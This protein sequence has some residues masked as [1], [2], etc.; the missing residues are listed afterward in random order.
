[1]QRKR[2]AAGAYEGASGL[3]AGG[4]T[5]YAGAPGRRARGVD[6]DEAWDTRVGNE[7]D[8]YGAP[9]EETELG[10]Q[11][12]GHGG[13][14]GSSM[15]AYGEG[16]DRGRSRSRDAGVDVERRYHEET[17]AGGQTH[18]GDNPFGDQ[19]EAASLKDVSPRPH[20]ET[21]GLDQG[22]AKGKGSHDDSPTER[23]SVFRE[24][25]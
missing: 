1:M 10:E 19:H 22:H 17:A 21:Q 11:P 25:I 9:Y 24:G 4:G 5:A 8:A 23:R 3:E 12:Y 6:P 7:A 13:Y 16:D 14:G 20:V 2:T 18:L 15:P